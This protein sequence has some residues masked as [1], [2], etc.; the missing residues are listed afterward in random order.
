MCAEHLN[1]LL[2]CG[3]EVS[4]KIII[5][6]Y[7]KIPDCHMDVQLRVNPI[8]S[9]TFCNWITVNGYLHVSHLQVNYTCLMTSFSMFPSVI[10]T[11]GKCY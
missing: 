4:P 7:K 11:Y 2:Y 8:S 6:I 10:E 1:H 3:F 5:F 9:S